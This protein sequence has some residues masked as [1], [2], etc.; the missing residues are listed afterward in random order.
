MRYA[1]FSHL[2]FPHT[3]GVESFTH[4]L[5]HE[6]VR[7]GNEVL[8]VTMRIDNSPEYEKQEDDV[9]V[10]RLPCY[11][12]M[13]GRL[14]WTR[15]SAAY[16]ALFKQALAWKADRVLVNT[17]F[18]PHS[19]EGLKYAHKLDAPAVLLDHGSAYLTVGTSGVDK[20]LAAFEH[21]ITAIGKLYRPTFAGIS[22][23][24]AQWLET[25]GIATKIVIPNAIDADGFRSSA[26]QRDFRKELGISQADML[27][28]S[29]GR[30]EPEKGSL[31]LAKAARRFQH[32]QQ[33]VHFAIAGEGSLRGELE[34]V[35]GSNFHLLGNIGSADLARLLLSADVFCLPS[36]SEG[37]CTSLLEA[38][39]CSLPSI[40]TD[41]GGARELIPSREY[42]WILPN[43]SG[44]S[45]AQ[46]ISSVM[47]LS[48]SELASVGEKA[49]QLV[50]NSH[51]WSDTMLRLEEAYA[52]QTTDK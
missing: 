44:E 22:V 11:P 35:S 49:Y 6:L 39:A 19:V 41:V 1:I 25:F 14:P 27:V 30:L 18:Y 42:G 4:N 33:A 26:S 24:S 23:R 31:Q 16:R 13:S 3:G 2:Y 9:E 45:V 46:A 8:I 51:T 38:S 40:I 36:R 47:K 15:H 52:R 32:E 48:P 20:I 5:S 12:L 34:A 21:A 10:L 37:F 50:R 29:V 7:S 28:V 43:Q 17:R